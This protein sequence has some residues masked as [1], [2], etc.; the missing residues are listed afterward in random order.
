[1]SDL[2]RGG[3][4]GAGCRRIETAHFP[5]RN[6]DVFAAVADA[7][8]LNHRRCRSGTMEPHDRHA[9]GIFSSDQS[10]S[11]IGLNAV[12]IALSRAGSPFDATPF[13]VR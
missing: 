7:R 5:P 3:M 6:H 1:M 9:L 10:A 12:P 11:L 13:P 2:G 8:P 4:R